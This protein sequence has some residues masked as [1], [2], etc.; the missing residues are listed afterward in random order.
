MVPINE[1]S[2]EGSKMVGVNMGLLQVKNSK[3]IVQH[4]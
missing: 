3:G 1:D 4:A 2:Y